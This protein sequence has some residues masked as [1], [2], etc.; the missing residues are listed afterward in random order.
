MNYLQLTSI[1]SSLSTLE[2][3]NSH[4]YATGHSGLFCLLVNINSIK[5][6]ESTTRVTAK[7][8]TVIHHCCTIQWQTSLRKQRRFI[9]HCCATQQSCSLESSHY[10]LLTQ[11]SYII[12][13][14]KS[15]FQNVL[16]HISFSSIYGVV[17]HAPTPLPFLH[18]FSTEVASPGNNI[19]Y[20]LTQSFGD[21]S[22]RS[23]TC[24]E[25]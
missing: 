23:F 19:N 17:L 22:H 24:W 7:T 10:L 1:N 15:S 6:R 16:I 2:H 21:P 12:Q 18:K 3:Q 14:P 8:K 5:T 11:S 13:E 25:H 20:H 4:T 9:L